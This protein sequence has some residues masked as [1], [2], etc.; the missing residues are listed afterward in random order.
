MHIVRKPYDHIDWTDLKR[1]REQTINLKTRKP[2]KQTEI[3][4]H[5]GMTQAY[6]SKIESGKIRSPSEDLVKGIA[7]AF[8]TTVADLCENL[9]RRGPEKEKQETTKKALEPYFNSPRVIPFYKTPCN[10][11]GFQYED[12]VL[13]DD[14][15]YCVPPPKIMNAPSSF[16]VEVP[17]DSM[18]PRYSRGDTVY[19][20]PDISPYYGDDV[21]VR[22]FYENKTII[23]IRHFVDV[24]GHVEDEMDEPIPVYGLVT[25]KDMN[26]AM[27]L[28][29]AGDGRDVDE[30]TASYTEWF[31]LF[32]EY[33][34][35]PSKAR[36]PGDP[37][38]GWPHAIN[39]DVIVGCDRNKR[40]RA[41]TPFKRYYEVNPQT[42]GAFGGIPDDPEDVN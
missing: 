38:E 32:P 36:I 17:T 11:K 19:V 8:R 26:N 18:F 15:D 1:L 34:D 25:F 40:W 16:A 10:V 4:T 5:A 2:M 7:A 39:V 20:D 23:L 30:L 24:D 42:I 9:A 12:G 41:G 33:V 37:N 14:T 31:P 21:V 22:L 28:K 13:I 6:Y 27:A 35:P 3:A 29:I